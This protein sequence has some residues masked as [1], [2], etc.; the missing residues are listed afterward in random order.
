MQDDHEPDQLICPVCG[1]SDAEGGAC[2]H[3][4]LV[5]D[6]DGRR[7]VDGVL[8]DTFDDAIE[9]LERAA[10]QADDPIQA[11][12]DAYLRLLAGLAR[13]SDGSAS[14]HLQSWVTQTSEYRGFYLKQPDDGPAREALLQV[15]LNE[16][17]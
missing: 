11:E 5:V 1:A 15:L 16:V 13:A 8:I 4:M 12:D 9:A 2:V 3:L 7:A 14:I 10:E 17:R 6:I